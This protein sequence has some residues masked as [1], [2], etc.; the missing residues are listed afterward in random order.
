LLTDDR[1]VEVKRAHPN[2]RI[3]PSSHMRS[4]KADAVTKRVLTKMDFTILRRELWII[5]HRA[6]CDGSYTEGTYKKKFQLC[7]SAR[8]PPCRAK[9]RKTF[10]L[11]RTYRHDF[12]ADRQ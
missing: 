11:Q 2:K 7:K 5:V 6:G 4:R 3:S 10:S 1:G 9:Q 8:A 12:L